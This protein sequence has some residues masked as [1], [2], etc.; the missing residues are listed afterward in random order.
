MNPI[1]VFRKIDKKKLSQVETVFFVPYK[2][3]VGYVLESKI[4]SINRQLLSMTNMTVLYSETILIGY[5]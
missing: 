1:P 4:G 2:S 5:G 3:H